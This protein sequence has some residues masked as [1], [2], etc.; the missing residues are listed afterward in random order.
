[1]GWTT[2]FLTAFGVHI[3]HGACII[4]PVGCDTIYKKIF[5]SFLIEITF[6]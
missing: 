5:A 1:M 4:D 6:I 3:T 2:P